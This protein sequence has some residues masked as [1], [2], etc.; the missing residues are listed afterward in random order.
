MRIYTIASLSSQQIN[1]NRS[2]RAPQG[3]LPTR[4][5]EDLAQ[6]WTYDER[7][8]VNPPRHRSQQIK[9][10]G[11]AIP[12]SAHRSRL[13]PALVSSGG[14]G[15]IAAHRLGLLALATTERWQSGR[16]RRTRNAE[17]GQPYRGFE[18]LPLRHLDVRLRSLT[19]R[20]RFR[21]PVFSANS[22]WTRSAAVEP[23][24][25]TGLRDLPTA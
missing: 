9:R 3:T 16:S 17:Y 19:F 8:A 4:R 25:V 24:S 10:P 14:V 11:A 18:S 12:R 7:R 1:A 21:K 23:G 13:V 6:R 20:N 22:V 2:Q 5:Q 15:Y